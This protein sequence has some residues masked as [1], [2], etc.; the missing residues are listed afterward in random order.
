MINFFFDLVL[1]GPHG[2]P[3]GFA[4]LFPSTGTPVYCNIEMTSKKPCP[5]GYDCLR[6]ISSGIP[7]CCSRETIIDNIYK[8]KFL[9]KIKN[10]NKIYTPMSKQ[11][12]GIEFSPRSSRSKFN[13]TKKQKQKQKGLDKC[14]KSKVEVKKQIGDKIIKICVES[15][16]KNQIPIR[17]SCFNFTHSDY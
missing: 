10:K 8:K 2:C 14:P 11:N 3:S 9:Q 5:S 17:G 12:L 16:P 1:P 13:K 4:Y 15:C 7:Q 6:H